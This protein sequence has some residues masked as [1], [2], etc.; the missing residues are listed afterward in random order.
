MMN[1]APKFKVGQ[2][3]DLLPSIS[4]LAA[5]GHYEIVSFR[6]ADGEIPHIG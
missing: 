4:R 5:N 2:S 3:V 6:P 1:L